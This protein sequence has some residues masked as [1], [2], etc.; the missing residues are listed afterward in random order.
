M[1]TRSEVALKLRIAKEKK[2]QRLKSYRKRR[3]MIKEKYIR[4][5]LKVYMKKPLY[6]DTEYN[7]KDAKNVFRS[8]MDKGQ[9]S[10]HPLIKQVVPYS[11]GSEAEYK[12]VR[13]V[14]R[15]IHPFSGKDLV[16]VLTDP[17]L[18]I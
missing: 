1:S 11:K 15:G 7:V 3:Q 4:P 5:R 13:W 2:E 12:L 18:I 17:F 16:P 8:R 14:E 6:I 9:W 10:Y